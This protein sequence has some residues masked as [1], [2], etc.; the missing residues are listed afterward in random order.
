MGC[1]RYIPGCVKPS[2]LSVDGLGRS[3]VGKETRKGPFAGDIAIRNCTARYFCSSAA[4]LGKS[5]WWALAAGIIFLA[6]L[7]ATAEDPS[8]R[9]EEEKRMVLASRQLEN[10][11]LGAD[12]SELRSWALTWLIDHPDLNFNVCTAFLQ[13][14]LDSDRRFMVEINLQFAYTNPTLPTGGMTMTLLPTRVRL[15]N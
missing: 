5:F 14:Y 12:S 13:P 11:P 15:R 2:I 1:F 3:D 10:A 4:M 7:P 6:G 9:S 8:S